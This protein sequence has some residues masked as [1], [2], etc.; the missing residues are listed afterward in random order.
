[1]LFVVFVN[2]FCLLIILIHFFVYI[3]III[4]A[5]RPYAATNITT[6]VST[7]SANITF[8][9]PAI[10][11]TP[12]KYHVQF[13]G[14]EFQNVLAYSE[15]VTGTSDITATNLVY[16]IMLSDLEEDNTY[17]FTIVSSNCQGNSST[18]FA[19]FTTLPTGGCDGSIE[20]CYDYL[21]VFKYSICICVSLPNSNTLLS[22]FFF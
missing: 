21:F 17:N 5:R 18:G 7:R 20:Y 6:S 1:M 19:S 8:T 9:I 4:A 2:L 10:A 13:I 12:E 22:K 3:F 14:F 11:Y 16:T 15:L